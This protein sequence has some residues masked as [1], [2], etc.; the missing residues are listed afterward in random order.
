[1]IK[2]EQ[3]RE[4]EI[5]LQQVSS[6]GIGKGRWKIGWQIKNNGAYPLAI[7]SA[8]LPHG[9]FKA[10]EQ[11]FDPKLILAPGQY[12]QF[13]ADVR[14][15]EPT[16]EVTENAF[17]IFSVGWLG[18]SWRVFARVRVTVAPNGEPVATTESATTQRIGFSGV[19]S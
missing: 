1:M 17:V 8:R 12:R 5:E 19:A 15:D 14:C 18:E 13:Q 16:G 3:D 2:I 11:Q 6:Q 9:Q 10:G 7:F 4:P